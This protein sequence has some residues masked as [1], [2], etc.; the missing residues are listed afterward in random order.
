MGLEISFKFEEMFFHE[1]PAQPCDAE[2]GGT[3][4]QNVHEHART[5]SDRAQMEAAKKDVLEM[6]LGE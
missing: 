4:E 5:V 6:P 3:G 1:M 2:G